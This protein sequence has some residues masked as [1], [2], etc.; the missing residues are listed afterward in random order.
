MRRITDRIR[1]AR[2]RLAKLYLEQREKRLLRMQAQLADLRKDVEERRD[3]LDSHVGVD[4]YVDVVLIYDGRSHKGIAPRSALNV[5]GP[6][7][8]QIPKKDGVVDE[9]DEMDFSWVVF[10]W[11]STFQAFVPQEPT[12]LDFDAMRRR[13]QMLHLNSLRGDRNEDMRGSQEGG[14]D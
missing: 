5:E 12:P 6:L 10:V 3:R 14:T 11:N 9:H 4:D 1:S 8:F 7:Q 2:R 13:G